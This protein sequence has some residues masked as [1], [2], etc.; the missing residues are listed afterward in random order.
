MIPIDGIYLKVSIL[1]DD[2]CMREII[3]FS[4]SVQVEYP[5]SDLSEFMLF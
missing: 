3:L 5:L 1:V 4:L 2:G